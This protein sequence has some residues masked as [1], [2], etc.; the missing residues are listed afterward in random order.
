MRTLVATTTLA[1]VLALAFVPAAQAQVPPQ[2]TPSMTVA[3][4]G[5]PAQFSGLA[6]NA[7]PEVPFKVDVTLRNVVCAQATSIP[8]T[9]TVSAA[10]A[11]AFFTVKADPESGAVNVAAGPY[12]ANAASGSM[13][14]KLVATIGEILANA[15]VPV[16]VK[17]T[18]SAPAG[19]NGA[20]SV[21]GAE[22]SATVYANMTAP[23]PP[24]P[25]TPDDNDSPGPGALLGVLAAMG[26]A[27]LRRR[28]SA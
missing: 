1:F 19:C 12:M 15:S 18:A 25:P 24:P 21:P 26:A 8:V 14:A 6:S 13:D 9:L 27:A 11:P 7:T 16:E 10:G 17:A 5:L 23:P 4:S 3:I 28:R 20:G 2:P 22:A